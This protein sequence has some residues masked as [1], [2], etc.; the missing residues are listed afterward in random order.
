MS[1]I[2]RELSKHDLIDKETG[3][4]TIRGTVDESA[5]LGKSSLIIHFENSSKPSPSAASHGQAG[6]FCWELVGNTVLR[7]IPPPGSIRTVDAIEEVE[8]DIDAVGWPG[9]DES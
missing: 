8:D 3:R 2:H 7:R 1:D 5:S 9:D 6:P 4:S